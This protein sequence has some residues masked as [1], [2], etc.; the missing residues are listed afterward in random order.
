MAR[1]E[2]WPCCSH[3][4]GCCP[5]FDES[6]KQLNMKCTCG[7]VLPVDARYSICD[8]CMNMGSEDGEMGIF[9][10]YGEYEPDHGELLENEE[11]EQA[12]EHF[13]PAEDF[14]DFYG[15]D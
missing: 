15:D 10:G 5:D 3:E 1:C 12:D 6:G 14:G 4:A 2:D 7:A 13:R 9:E 11:F 8:A